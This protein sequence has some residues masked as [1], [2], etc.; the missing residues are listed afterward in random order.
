MY[1]WSI[2]LT[3]IEG[4]GDGSISEHYYIKAKNDIDALDSAL[5]SF[6]NEF[7]LNFDDDIENI[8]WSYC[9]V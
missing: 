3:Y 5:T 4:Y 2:R 1:T 7:G 8:E 6:L 9:R